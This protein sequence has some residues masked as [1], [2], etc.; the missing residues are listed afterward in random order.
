M[1]ESQADKISKSKLLADVAA[2]VAKLKKI[3]QQQDGEIERMKTW[4]KDTLKP[5][6]VTMRTDLVHIINNHDYNI[7]NK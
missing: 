2:D 6:L 7:N 5:S 4:I 1:S 3:T